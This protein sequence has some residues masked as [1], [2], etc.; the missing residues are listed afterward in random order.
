MDLEAII[1]NS[2]N[3]SLKEYKEN[4]LLTKEILVYVW[5]SY[6]KKYK[7]GFFTGN[8]MILQS[9]FLKRKVNFNIS[10]SDE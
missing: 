7:I 10:E 4:Q 9:K 8:T 1:L 3:K 5:S 6:I 2:K